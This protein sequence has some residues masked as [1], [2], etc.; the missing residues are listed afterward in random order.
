M[1]FTEGGNTCH[2][3]NKNNISILSEN[4]Q[5]EDDDSRNSFC[6]IRH[7]RGREDQNDNKNNL[8]S[9]Q[10]RKYSQTNSNKSNL[11]K[12]IRISQNEV[13][14]KEREQALLVAKKHNPH[15]YFKEKLEEIGE[16]IVNSQ[17]LNQ[18]GG[19]LM[20]V[21]ME[22]FENDINVVNI[23]EIHKFDSI[24]KL[25]IRPNSNNTPSI[26]NLK[27]NLENFENLSFFQKIKK[28]LNK[29][30]L[31]DILEAVFISGVICYIAYLFNDKFIS[32]SNIINYLSGNPKVLMLLLIIIAIFAFLLI[33]SIKSKKRANKLL[34]EK[35]LKE[36]EKQLRNDEPYILLELDHFIDEYCKITNFDK[37]K[38]KSDVL[39][40]MI[41]AL[42]I[43]DSVLIEKNFILDGKLKRFILLKS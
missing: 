43:K 17:I 41:E 39:P 37:N 23:N 1:N 24:P 32:V 40:E 16:K 29:I 19:R 34:A 11:S 7:K 10:E 42:K 30:T 22:I 26:R 27:E 2:K 14:M 18:A 20:D 12:I 13:F 8:E 33:K 21:N 5:N 9:Y 3:N 35:A 6:L 25:H 31:G 4:S 28:S 15:I 36:I 38:F